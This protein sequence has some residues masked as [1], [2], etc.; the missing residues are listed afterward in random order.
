MP[1]INEPCSPGSGTCVGWTGGAGTAPA[2]TGFHGPWA[3]A[4]DSP[5]SPSSLRNDPASWRS[6]SPLPLTM[7]IQITVHLYD[8]LI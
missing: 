5:S 7:T 4:R 1:L 8:V 3:A 6:S 2:G